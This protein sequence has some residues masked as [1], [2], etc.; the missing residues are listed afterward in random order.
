MSAAVAAL[1]AA[2]TLDGATLTLAPVWLRRLSGVADRPGVRVMRILGARQLVQAALTAARPSPGG[3]RAGAAVDALHAT[4]MIALAL[5]DRRRC[6]A[7]LLSAAG[8]AGFA[9]AG[10]LDS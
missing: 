4:S 8:A 3:L 2:R 9:L 6:R 7:A 1:T 10:L 5:G